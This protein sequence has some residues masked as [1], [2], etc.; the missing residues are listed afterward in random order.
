MFNTTKINQL[1]YNA[2]E[3]KKKQQKKKDMEKEK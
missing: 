1:L 3:K 2:Y